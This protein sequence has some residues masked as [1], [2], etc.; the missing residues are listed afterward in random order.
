MREILHIQA[1]QAG[2]QIGRRFWEV[3]SEEHAIGADGRFAPG[4]GARSFSPPPP[5]AAA[6][7]PPRPL[8]ERKPPHSGGS[9]RSRATHLF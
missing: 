1:G 9:L 6:P 7:L 5:A 2:N 4:E 3:I 8:P